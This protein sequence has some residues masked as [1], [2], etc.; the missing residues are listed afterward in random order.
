MPNPNDLTT[1]SA[2]DIESLL[3]AMKIGLLATL[4]PQGLPHITLLSSI[5]ASSPAQLAFGQFIEGQSKKHILT[6]PKV[7]FLVMSLDRHLWRGK[8]TY[9]HSARAGK[10]YDYYNNIPMF[11]YNA[12]FGVHTVYYFDLVSQTGREA[13]PMNRII[14]AALQSLLARTLAR[15]LGAPAVLNPWTRSFLNKLDNLKFLAYVGADG[16]PELI[17]A[18]QAQCLDAGHVVFSTSVYQEE[19]KAIPAGSSLAVMGMALTMEDVLVRGT[20]QGLRWVGGVR[21]GVVEVDWVYNSMPPV[22]GQIYPPQ[23]ITPVTKF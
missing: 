8:A 14:V 23:P 7:G 2:Q 4:N 16:Y 9:T 5:I 12:Y 18:V 3:P 11:R 22:P 21:C 1:F 15:P 19:L 6:Q 13:L 17:P 10:D 20:Y